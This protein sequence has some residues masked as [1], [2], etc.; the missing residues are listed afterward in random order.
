[1]KATFFVNGN[2]SSFA[3]EIYKRIVNE[4]HAI[5]NHTYTHNYATQYSSV[6]AFMKDL[7]RLNTLLKEVVNIEPDIMRFPGGSNNTVSRKYGGKTVMKEIQN[8]LKEA[9]PNM[10]YYDW[11]VDSGDANGKKL[12]SDDIAN[13]VINGTKT[14]SRAIVL[15]HDS[16][17]KVQTVNALN[18]I[19]TELKSLGYSFE[20]LTSE[21]KP[22]QFQ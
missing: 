15:M 6:E 8:H 12:T 18:K 21:V 9:K 16:K 13:N 11:N 5:G 2:N 3:K 17:P 14:K 10:V 1:M 7:N 20:T 19:I 22:V 4:G